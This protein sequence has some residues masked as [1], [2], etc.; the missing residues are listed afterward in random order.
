M[1]DTTNADYAGMVAV[2]NGRQ[3]RK[4]SHNT[5]ARLEEDGRIVVK[6]HDTDILTFHPNGEVE[7]QSGGWLTITT[8][9]RMNRF[10]AAGVTISQTKGRWFV[11]STRTSDWLH[12]IREPLSDYYEG[13]RVRDGQVT[14]GVKHSGDPDKKIKAAIDRYVKLYT[15]EKVAELIAASERGPL[16]DC[17]Y[18]QMRVQ[19]TGVPLGEHTGDHDH[20]L[21][22]VKDRYVQISTIY[23]AVVAAGYRV[24]AVILHGNCDMA[25][26]ALRR[27]LRQR[28][29]T[30]TAGA[31]AKPISQGF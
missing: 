18:C 24:P 6:L 21:Q 4:I 19:G 9:E 12:G 8:K 7:Y 27:Y 28:L 10:G 31:G 2:L 15:D 13:I 1:T 3:H 25:R 29:A 16:G 22:H 14:T 5:Y 23:N 26:R 17:W 11:Y 20:L 30:H